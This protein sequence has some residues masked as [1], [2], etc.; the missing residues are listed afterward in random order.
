MSA[1][2]LLDEKT[3]KETIKAWAIIGAILDRGNDAIIRKKESG[4]LIIEEKKKQYIAPPTDR[5]RGRTVGVNYRGFL[6]G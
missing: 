4:F 1:S 2:R 6:G 3:N 5:G